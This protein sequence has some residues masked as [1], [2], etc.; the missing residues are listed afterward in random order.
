MH[1]SCNVNVSYVFKCVPL[2]C[3]LSS[4]YVTAKC[5]A[6]TSKWFTLLFYLL[7]FQEIDT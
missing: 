6:Q 2:L 3:V 7:N 1:T 4:N 5:E